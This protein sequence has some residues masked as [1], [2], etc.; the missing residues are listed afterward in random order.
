MTTWPGLRLASFLF[1]L[2]TISLFVIGGFV[3]L[4]TCE[5]EP[6]TIISNDKVFNKY[7]SH[8]SLP[9]SLFDINRNEKLDASCH[10]DIEVEWANDVFSGVYSTPLIAD[11]L[12]LGR[13]QVIVASYHQGIEILDGVDG[14]PLPGW[15]HIFPKKEFVASPF[16]V[17]IDQDGIQE[18]G[19]A[20]KDGQIFFF[21]AAGF[22]LKQ[23]TITLEKLSVRKDWHDGLNTE[24]TVASFS[25]FNQEMGNNLNPNARSL[26]E[27]NTDDDSWPPEE[28]YDD[29]Y[30]P[31]SYYNYYD[32]NP[33]SEK[34]AMNL[35]IVR[36]DPHILADPIIADINKDGALELIIPV[37]YYF[38][39][40]KYREPVK[41]SQLGKDV[42]ISKYV[43]SAIAIYDL[44]WHI[45]QKI[46]PLDLTTDRT[47]FRAY[48]VA[49]PAVY[50]IDNDNHNDIIV[51]STVGFI[52]AFD[53]FGTL[54]K[55]F[56]ITMDEIHS[57]VLVGDFRN[58]GKPIIIAVDRKGNLVAFGANGEE[59][60]E[61][62]VSGFS[63]EKLEIADIDADGHLD[64][65]FATSTG[66]IWAF[67]AVDGVKLKNF[68]VKVGKEI[69]APVLL[70][71]LSDYHRELKNSLTIVVMTIEG[72]LVL[73]DSSATCLEKLDL[74]EQS[75]SKVLAD[76]VTGNGNIDLVI[77]TKQGNIHCLGTRSLYH[78]LKTTPSRMN[79]QGI[80]ILDATR[81]LPHVT[82]G[83]FNIHFE[84]VDNRN[85][86]LLKDFVGLYRVRALLG[87]SIV[88]HEEVFPYAGV[89][90]LKISSPAKRITTN[91][92]LELTNER[93]DIFTDSYSVSFNTYFYRILKWLIT[94]PFLGMGLF[95]LFAKRSD[96][97][98][99]L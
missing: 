68:P 13:K 58:N 95:I 17:D 14:Q 36:I 2:F 80:Y 83:S 16:L 19:V 79:Y 5:I 20:S 90:M 47:E 39:R 46:I 43:A 92:V 3:Q 32:P 98:L 52:Y 15:P 54:K 1:R 48:L 51:P 31:E 75:F 97:D 34:E 65:V 4:I 50:D 99:P 88:L 12:G 60:W 93:N 23:Y 91:V 96:S 56:P 85:I 64:V 41:R 9:E 45:M 44:R 21:S 72:Y 33:E 63:S 42:D 10:S 71:Q 8:T 61:N 40:E 67:S 94:L 82:G 55:N 29:Y 35:N 69:K 66:Y 24:N 6:A 76:D 7:R 81:S 28:Y 89:F 77:A 62:R 70:T 27:V 38:D 53:S 73:L 59:V 26:K 37:T 18:L 30:D 84:I 22:L 25:L 11:F 86:T 49:S 74:G 78:P 87:G 57:Q